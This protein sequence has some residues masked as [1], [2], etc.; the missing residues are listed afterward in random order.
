[1]RTGV[2]EL[3]AGNTI[4]RIQLEMEMSMISKGHFLCYEVARINS[5][6]SEFHQQ[7]KEE[8]K[9]SHGRKLVVGAVS[10]TETR[11][12]CLLQSRGALGCFGGRQL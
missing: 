7:K 3:L 4:I 6:E 5:R 1:M 2:L 11:A 10:K 12:P 9:G 8:I